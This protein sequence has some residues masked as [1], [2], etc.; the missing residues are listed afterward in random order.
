[1]KNKIALLV[2][3][4]PV[5]ALAQVIP[6]ESGTFLDAVAK[7]LN[8]IPAAAIASGLIALEFVLRFLPTVKP[9]SILVPVKKGLDVVVFILNYTGGLLEKVIVMANNVK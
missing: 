2:F 7:F 5:M 4:L 1:M 3:L 6:P 8:D 9:A